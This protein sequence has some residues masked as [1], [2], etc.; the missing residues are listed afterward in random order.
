MKLFKRKPSLIVVL[1]ESLMVLVAAVFIWRGIWVLL[2]LFDERFFRGNHFWTA[3]AG[4]AFGCVMVYFA[5]RDLEDL[6]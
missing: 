3:L 6:V 2:D 5:D 1:R 4:I